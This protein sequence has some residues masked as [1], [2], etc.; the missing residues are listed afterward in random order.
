[1]AARKKARS[2]RTSKGAHKRMSSRSSSSS[3]RRTSASGKSLTT[4]ATKAI[5]KVGR[6]M[7]IVDKR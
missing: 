1:M 3:G 7:G 2:A 6:K 4:R 5:K